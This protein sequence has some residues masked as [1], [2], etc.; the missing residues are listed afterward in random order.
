LFSESLFSE[1]LYS[2]NAIIH[3][4]YFLYYFSNSMLT[5]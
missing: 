1:N 3:Q 4:L 2:N 5:M